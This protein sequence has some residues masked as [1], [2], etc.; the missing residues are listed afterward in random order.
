MSSPVSTDV[1]REG[2][3][4]FAEGADGVGG[5]IRRARG[6]E[7]QWGCGWSHLPGF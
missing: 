6:A 3:I 7:E 5:W 2:G 1:K 4:S